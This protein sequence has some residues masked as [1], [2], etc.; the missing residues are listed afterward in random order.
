[1]QIGRKSLSLLCA[2]GMF[3][4]VMGATPA[5]AQRKSVAEELIEILQADGKI[6]QSKAD[7]LR[8]RA[9]VEN[10][11]REAGVEAFRRDPVKAV[12]ADQDWLSRLSFSGDMRARWEGFYQENGDGINSRARNRERIRLRLGVKY[13]ISDE[14]EGGLRLVSGDPNDPISSNQTMDNLFT[15]KPISLDQAYITFTPKN[16]FSLFKDMEW[17]PFSITAGKFA[18]PLFRPRAGISSEMV[19]DDDL[20]PEG[21]NQTFT[22]YSA[23]EGLL[24]KLQLHVMEWALK[25]A[26]NRADSWMLGGQLV[27]NFALTPSM[28]LTLAVADYNF[29]KP[30]LLAQQI[31][32]NSSLKYTNGLLFRN[33][34]GVEKIVAGGSSQ[35][36]TLAGYTLR[37]FASGWNIFN[38]SGQLDIKT[39]YPQWPVGLFFDYALNTKAYNDRD[40]AIWAGASVGMLKNPGDWMFS[41]AWGRVETESV[42]SMF[43]FS[44]FGRDGGT[45]VT[46]PMVRVDYLL[47]PRL[48]LTAK[49]HFVSLI[50]RPHGHSNSMVNRMQLDAVLSF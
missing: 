24:R 14:I 38:A 12:K 45:N 47:L 13:K 25:E 15:K 39:A 32:S 35:K 34:K 20:N 10:E 21:A 43:S 33:A 3:A 23:G 30:R 6:S 46:G 37:N 5:F 36:S 49:N 16:S 26:S 40:T 42:L 31:A 8:Q 29:V 27:G 4:G 44:D 22:F 19:W 1:M 17:A 18:N 11:A 9:K 7:E 2:G 48:T 50:D 41:A 28:N